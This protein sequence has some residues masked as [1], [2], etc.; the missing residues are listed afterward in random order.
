MPVPGKALLKLLDKM[1]I[2]SRTFQWHASNAAHGVKEAAKKDWGAL[3]DGARAVKDSAA[4]GLGAA[5]DF[6]RENPKTS[7]AVGG[8]GAGIGI[9]A[10]ARRKKQPEPMMQQ[11]EEMD[12]DDLIKYLRVRRP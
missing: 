4:S 8:I 1:D 3:K 11:G 5:R 9:A 2:D 10:L 7:S 12:D 6:V